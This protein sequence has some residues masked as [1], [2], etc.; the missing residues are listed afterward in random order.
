MLYLICI[1][2]CCLVMLTNRNCAK[3]TIIAFE[4]K[5]TAKLLYINELSNGDRI[6]LMEVF[7]WLC[8]RSAGRRRAARNYAGRQISVQPV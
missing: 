1:L 5:F 4:Y 8:L 3:N 7:S 6:G 2:I